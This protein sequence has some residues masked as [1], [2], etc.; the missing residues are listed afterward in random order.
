MDTTSPTP[1]PPPPPT[2][3]MGLFEGLMDFGF[4]RFITLNVMKVL[5]MLGIALLCL[6]WLG[7]VIMGFTMGGVVGGL[8]AIVF[9]TILLLVQLIFLRVWMELIVVL[10]RI[11]DNTTKLVQNT[12]RP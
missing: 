3:S 10:F 6:Y 12:T 9:G 2:A 7:I 1:A 11:G 8:G 4:T 5:Y